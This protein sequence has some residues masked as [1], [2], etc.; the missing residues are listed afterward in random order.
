MQSIVTPLEAVLTADHRRPAIR[1]RAS[2]LKFADEGIAYAIVGSSLVNGTDLVQGQ[3]VIITNADFFDYMDESE[4]AMRLDYDRRIDEP[5]G[6]ISYAI[7]NI[8]L[9][10]ITKRFTPEHNAT[11]GTAIEARRPFKMSVGFEAGGQ[12]RMVQVLVG[13]TANRPKQGR[14]SRT[15]T[16]DIYDYITFIN[17]AQIAAAVYEDQRGDEIIE[18]ILVTLGFGSVQYSLDQSLNTI[19]FAWFDKNK[20]AGERI[21]EICEAEEATFYQDENGILRFENRNHVANYPHQTPVRTIDAEDII[22]DEDDDSTKIINR[23]I[24]TAKPRRVDASTSEIWSHG[25]VEAIPPLGS[26]TIW[27]AFYDDTGSNVQPVKEITTPASTTDY[28]GNAAP[29]GSGADRTANLSV[30]VTNFVE[31]AKIVISN[32]HA[33][34]TVYLTLDVANNKAI[35][36]R[37]KAARV[38]QAIQAVEEDADSINKFEAQEHAVAN[39]LIQTPEMAQTMAENLVGRYKDPMRRRKIRIP[40]IP[41]LQLKDLVNVVNPEA[42]D[43]IPNGGFEINTDN[44]QLVLGGTAAGTLSKTREVPIV[45]GFFCGKVDITNN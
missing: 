33:T 10:N 39:N 25:T 15:V 4:Y 28:V 19:P 20:S 17:N 38:I 41:H 26:I 1:V 11:I 21:R 36:L 27:A 30:E 3:S 29:D 6:G 35:A 14:T 23:A 42:E 18:D 31:T 45:Q 34:D 2:W 44:W 8:L 16:V 22:T 13:L 5:R 9:D 24:V 7:A 43:L 32:D 37:G 40:G 12:D